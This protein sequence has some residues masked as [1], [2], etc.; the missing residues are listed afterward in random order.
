MTERNKQIKA[1]M[2][3]AIALLPTNLAGEYSLNDY[4]LAEKICS[5]LYD[6]NFVKLTD[7]YIKFLKYAGTVERYVNREAMVEQFMDQFQIMLYS[8]VRQ[9]LQNALKTDWKEVNNENKEN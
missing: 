4:A 1:M 2:D 9:F 3:I 5:A 8:N 7:D 6:N